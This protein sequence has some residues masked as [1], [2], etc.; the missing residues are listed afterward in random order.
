[1]RYKGR[2]L[3]VVSS[4]VDQRVVAICFMLT[5]SKP[6]FPSQEIVSFMVISLIN[7]LM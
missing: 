6:R 2:L 7:W 1:M 4:E 5:L 3:V